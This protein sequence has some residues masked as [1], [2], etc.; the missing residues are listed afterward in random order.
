M[1][2]Y[3]WLVAVDRDNGMQ[4]RFHVDAVNL[5][6]AF[7]LTGERCIGGEITCIKRKQEVNNELQAQPEGSQSGS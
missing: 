2:Q 6:H 1:K 4:E 3:R 5:M 7:I